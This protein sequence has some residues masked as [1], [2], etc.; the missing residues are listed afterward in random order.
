MSAAIVRL[1]GV[2]NYIAKYSK[3]TTKTNNHQQEQHDT[4][5]T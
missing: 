3:P 1:S 4:Y 2:E 5:H